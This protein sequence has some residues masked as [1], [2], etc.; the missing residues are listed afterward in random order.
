MQLD[1]LT[2]RRPVH[3]KAYRLR[4]H[5]RNAG[6]LLQL[7][8]SPLDRIRIFKFLARD[9]AYRATGRPEESLLRIA[10]ITYCLGHGGGEVFPL[11]EMGSNHA[12][13]QVEDFTP[14]RGWTVVDAGANVGTYSL[15]QAVR[16]A[17]VHA[18][19]PNPVCCERLRRAANANGVKVA[20]TRAALGAREGTAVLQFGTARSTEAK[21][22]ES[23]QGVEVRLIPLDGVVIGHVDLMKIDV[24]FAEVEVLKGATETLKETSRVVLE[25]HSHELLA[26]SDELLRAAG[27][28]RRLLSEPWGGSSRYGYGV[29]YYSR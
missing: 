5:L 2:I 21:V 26:Q 25:F 20:I 28:T 29:A 14:G 15:Q 22:A 4:R 10:G 27:L 1:A 17:A 11:I 9:L 3:G 6:L 16:G 18:F 24:E 8:Q 19:E 12:Y 13:D 7:A 23:G